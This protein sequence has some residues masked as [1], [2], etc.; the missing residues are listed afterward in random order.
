MYDFE[1]MILF[2]FKIRE[3]KMDSSQ[4]VSLCLQGGL[5]LFTVVLAIATCKLHQSTK[6]YAEATKLQVYFS[7]IQ[8]MASA[9]G[10]E[11]NKI[12]HNESKDFL[13]AVKQDYKRIL[14]DIFK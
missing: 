1:F 13:D 5:L 2:L 10:G 8:A 7:L 12:I 4:I 14:E 6:R 3:V 9:A 11:P